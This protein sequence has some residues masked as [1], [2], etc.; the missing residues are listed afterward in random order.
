MNK[1][2]LVVAGA[3]ACTTGLHAKTVLWYHFDEAAPGTLTT[4]SSVIVDSAGTQNGVP[5][6]WWNNEKGSNAAFMPAYSNAFPNGCVW[7]DPVS[8]QRGSLNRCLHIKNPPNYGEWGNGA[9]GVVRIPDNEAFHLQS[10]TIEMFVKDLYLSD[11]NHTEV[12]IRSSNHYVFYKD[13]SWGM[14][15][16]GGNGNGSDAVLKS[17]YRNVDGTA[18]YWSDGV[19]ANRYPRTQRD[20]NWHHVALVVDGTDQTSVKVEVY[21][22]Y[23]KQ[24]NDSKTMTGPVFYDASDIWIGRYPLDKT[25]GWGGLIDEFRISDKALAPKEMLRFVNPRTDDDTL[26]YLSFDD[27]MGNMFKLNPCKIEPNNYL[28]N[29]SGSVDSTVPVLTPR[30]TATLPM[31]TEEGVGILRRDIAAQAGY[32]DLASLLPVTNVSRQTFGL[33]YPLTGNRIVT[34]DD[35]T[36]E[37]FVKRPEK[38]TCD[39]YIMRNYSMFASTGASASWYIIANPNDK[40]S[41]AV[42]WK[43]SVATPTAV[44][45]DGAW[46]HLAWVVTKADHTSRFYVDGKKIGEIADDNLCPIAPQDCADAGTLIFASYQTNGQNSNSFTGLLDE[47]RVTGRALE[48]QEF[49]TTRSPSSSVLASASFEN[50]LSEGPADYTD[51]FAAGTLDGTGDYA[52]TRPFKTVDNTKSIRLEGATVSLGRNI[53]LEADNEFTLEFFVRPGTVSRQANLI[54]LKKRAPL[55]GNIWSV[56]ISAD[57]ATLTV[58]AGSGSATFA[59]P[60]IADWWHHYGLVVTK[61]EGLPV[62]TL[63][64]DH[65]QIGQPVTLSAAIDFS[66]LTQGLVIGSAD[67]TGWFDEIRVTKG[68]LSPEAMMTCSPRQG[69]SLLLK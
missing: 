61:S 22:D 48:P 58:Q 3:F 42:N 65:V 10:F 19:N 39:E 4:S 40:V 31:F 51:L 23:V 57:K 24:F 27:W 33:T 68:A 55:D 62:L 18:T 5:E 35:F 46:H 45:A 36:I 47:L 8:G 21:V 17:I 6:Y 9:H 56:A 49:L 44:L 30:E 66:D 32:D 43:K 38:S 11:P 13:K 1:N 37:L 60:E 20:G 63:Y 41:F 12:Q 29:E 16:L 26:L 2:L 15:I 28:V 59:L 67:F 53:L 54:A 69:M 25:C 50:D 52:R 34:K 7:F 64:V 14:S